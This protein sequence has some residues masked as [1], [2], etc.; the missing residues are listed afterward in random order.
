MKN[1]RFNLLAVPKP[2]TKL[3]EEKFGG[4]W[5]YNRSSRWWYCDDGIRYAHYVSE[6]FNNE[7]YQD[8]FANPP[9]L[10]MYNGNEG[11]RVW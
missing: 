6:N 11:I 8:E 10:Y 2:V 3:L 1:K 5:T 9:S 7:Y 4:K